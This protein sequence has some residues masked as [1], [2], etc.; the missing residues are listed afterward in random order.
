MKLHRL[1][2]MG[3]CFFAAAGVSA[4]QITVGAL[5]DG[6]LFEDASGALSGGGSFQIYLGRLS[7]TG[8]E[9]KRRAVVAFNLSAIPASAT[10]TEV[11]LSVNL[12]KGNGGDTPVSMHRLTQDWGEGTT[13]GGPQG[14]VSATGDAT[15]QHTFKPTTWS[16]PGG[17]FVGTAS[18]TT[19][20]GVTVGNYTWNTTPELVAD[21][22]EWVSN[23]SGNFGWI[24]IGDEVNNTT[25]KMITSR[26]G[27]NGPSLTVTYDVP[28]PGLGLAGVMGMLLLVRRR[29][30]L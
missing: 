9:L 24:L 27:S 14:A 19:P 5:K 7:P 21:V 15:W 30:S 1:V 20:I 17:D 23:P 16:T 25:A 10:V 18:A 4:D 22:Q 26:E 3:V 28:E 13:S 6:T 12:E 29:Q 8:S 2:V 11:S